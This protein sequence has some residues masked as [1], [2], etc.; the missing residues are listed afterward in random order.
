M[1]YCYG[2]VDITQLAINDTQKLNI[3]TQSEVFALSSS[4]ARKVKGLYLRNVDTVVQPAPTDHET[5]YIRHLGDA[6][7]LTQ[8]DMFML[9]TIFDDDTSSVLHRPRENLHLH[10]VCEVSV[11]R[12]WFDKRDIGSGAFGTVKLQVISLI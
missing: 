9:E 11:N 2:G 1:K 4:E 8:H 3:V 5:S 7:P 6:S 12:R 10:R